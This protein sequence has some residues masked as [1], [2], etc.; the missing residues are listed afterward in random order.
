M[1]FV[2][3]LG[4]LGPKCAADSIFPTNRLPQ[5]CKVSLLR[6]LPFMC[7]SIVAVS[8]FLCCCF[9]RYMEFR[10]TTV[11]TRGQIILKCVRETELLLHMRV[12]QSRRPSVSL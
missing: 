7:V 2:P 4:W 8:N 12:K 10:T 5:L 6:F 1:A 11:F 9:S 3:T